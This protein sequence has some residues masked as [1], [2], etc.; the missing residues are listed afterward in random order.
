MKNTIIIALV[1]SVLQGK[2]QKEGIKPLNV[3]DKVPNIAISNMFN[4]QVRESHISDF[5]G[6]LLI[7]DFWGIHCASCIAEMP[8]ME[9]LQQQFGDSV[10]VLLVTTDSKKQVDELAKKIK[11]IRNIKLPIVTSDTL[12]SRLFPY[13]AL[14]LHV[15]IDGNS[16]VNQK[17]DGGAYVAADIENFLHKKKVSLTQ[18]N[19][20]DGYFKRGEPLW[21]Q[22]NG[23]QVKYIKYHSLIS[24]DLRGVASAGGGRVNDPITHKTTRI[25]VINMPIQFLYET[26]FKEYGK[27]SWSQIIWEVSDSSKYFV[28]ENQKM[29]SYEWKMTHSYCYEI[30]VDTS[31]SDKIYSMMQQD[32]ERYFDVTGSIEKRKIKCWSLVRTTISDSLFRSNN[33]GKP[34]VKPAGRDDVDSITL[35]K[36]PLKSL[37]E[38]LKNEENIPVIDETGYEGLIDI[39]IPYKSGSGNYIATKAALLKYGLDLQEVHRDMDCLILREKKQ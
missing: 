7:L 1:F 19:D 25:Y 37:V 28:P 9:K 39:S 23:R 11:I 13:N 20:D 35:H 30:Q 16:T 27:H 12:L 31:K 34:F 15:W 36:A 21:L 14:G 2:A 24:E 8:K 3:G 32:L 5:K 17:T 29:K 4:Y 26:A 18:R 22:G 38:Y 6:K 10:Q 33:E